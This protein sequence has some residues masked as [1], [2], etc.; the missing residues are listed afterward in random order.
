MIVGRSAEMRRVLS[1]IDRVAPTDST[2]LI[3]GETGTG[4]ELVAE[5]LHR[6]SRR[7]AGPLVKVD[8]ATLPAGLIESTLFGHE[9]GAFTDATARALGRF[10][11]A[12]GGTLFLDEIGEL[13]L[14]L[15]PKLLRVLQEQQFERLGASKTI[16]VDVRVIAATNRDLGAAVREGRF[17]DDL[18]YRLNVFPIQLPPLRD[19]KEDIPDLVHHWMRER[20]TGYS[21]GPSFVSDEVLAALTS[22]PW[23]GNVRE[24]NAVLE[25]A[26]I[27]SPGA[28][29]ELN[30]WTAG[31]PDQAEPNLSVDELLRRSELIEVLGRFRG[32]ISALGEYYGVHRKQIYRW[33]QKYGLSPEDYRHR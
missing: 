26:A 33:L 32:N 10:E 3:L 1:A 4:K 5:A 25:R 7:P 9:R 6:K 28:S 18:Y 23:P 17:R 31:S 12:N 8:C 13:P 11:L 27:L 29:L 16:A 14:Q 24:L 21:E 15:Q 2:V 22:H 20:A 30:D 19:R